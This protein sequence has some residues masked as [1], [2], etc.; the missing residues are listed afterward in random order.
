MRSRSTGATRSMISCGQFGLRRRRGAERQAV[1]RDPLHGVD[2]GGVGVAEDH[3]PPRAHQVDVAVAVGVG[4]PAALGRGDEPRGAADR[5]ERPHRR[6][7]PAGDDGARVGEQLRRH[8]GGV[9]AR[10]ATSVPAGPDASTTGCSGQPLGR[11]REHRVVGVVGQLA[12]VALDDLAGQGPVR[13]RGSAPAA[14]PG[15]PSA[16]YLW[17][18]TIHPGR[19]GR[20]SP[21]RSRRGWT[22][23][24]SPRR[25][26]ARPP[27]SAVAAC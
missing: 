4:Q 24:T 7:H 9:C 15:S 6:V 1:G 23:G 13:R 8:L 16:T 20:S 17:P 25:P 11:E 26:R 2:D 10:M 3:R 22:R 12:P 18:P 27:G 14:R 19:H 5:G 21:T